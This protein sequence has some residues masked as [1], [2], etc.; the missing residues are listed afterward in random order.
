HQPGRV[1][2]PQASAG[3]GERRLRRAFGSPEGEARRRRRRHS[4]A[5]GDRGGRDAR[6]CPGEI[7]VIPPIDARRDP[8]TPRFLGEVKLA[9]QPTVEV[10]AIPFGANALV[11]GPSSWGFGAPNAIPI[12]V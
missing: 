3:A 6:L 7:S 1:H 5:C 11:L 4:A 9:Q 10:P 12:P 2:G 8:W